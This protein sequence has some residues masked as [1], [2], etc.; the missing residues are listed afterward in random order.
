[1]ILSIQRIKSSFSPLSFNQFFFIL[2]LYNRLLFPAI[3]QQIKLI[4]LAIMSYWL[5]AIDGV[6]I[7]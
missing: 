6:V 5:V 1:V 7:D 3:I 2:P 4:L